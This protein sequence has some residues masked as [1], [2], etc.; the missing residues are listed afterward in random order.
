[1]EIL[2]KHRDLLQFLQGIIYPWRK[3]TVGIDGADGV[4]KSTLARFLCWQLGM[5]TL[6]TDMFLEKG[7][8]YP[9]IR[10]NELSNLIDCR[11]SLNRPVIVEGIYL[12]DTLD[13]INIKIDVLIY[14]EDKNFYGSITWQT[15][16]KQYREKYDPL[17]KADYIYKA[18]KKEDYR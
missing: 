16:L 5:P 9:F 6:E 15:E 3:L 1:M 18:N 13:R 7:K 14:V 17:G 10:Y 4:G 8:R 11:H 2:Q 12:L